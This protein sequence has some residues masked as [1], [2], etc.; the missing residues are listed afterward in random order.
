MIVTPKPFRCLSAVLLSWF[1]VASA[2]AEIAFSLTIIRETKPAYEAGY[3]QTR[4]RALPWLYTTNPPVS[5][6]RVE[7]PTDIC[8]ANFGTNTSSGGYAFHSPEPLWNALTNGQWKLWLNRDT[9]QEEFYTFTITSLDSNALAE[10]KINSPPNG[11]LNLP[12]LPPYTWTGPTNFDGLDVTVRHVTNATL[13][14]SA[15]EW[16]EGPT[17]AP[18]TNFFSV[19]YWRATTAN[20]IVSTPTNDVL[21]ALTNWTVDCI[22]LRSSAESGFITAGLPPDSLA[23][24]LDAPGLIWETGGDAPWFAQTTNASDGLD[25]AQSGVIP[26][27]G[28]T[29]LRTVLYGTNTIRFRWRTDCEVF[30]DYVEF[31]DNGNYVAD[32]TGQTVWQDFTYPLTDGQVHVLE[33]TYYKDFSEAT[34]ADAA[35]LDQVRLGADVLPTGPPLEFNL[36][37]SREQKP[38]HDPLAPNALWYSAIPGLIA[39]NVPLSYHE[40]RSPAGWFQATVGPTNTSTTIN[41]CLDFAALASEVTNGFWTLWLD[42]ET[43]QEQF[44][45]FRIDPTS[46]ASNDLNSVSITHPMNDAADVLPYTSF[47]WTGG[48]A[49]AAE[50]F[51]RAYQIRTNT[52]AFVY[53]EESLTPTSLVSWDGM[54]PL[55]PDTNF[56]TVRY[57]KAADANFSVSTPYLGWTQGNMRFE[58]SVTSSFVVARPQPTELLSPQIIG[59]EFQFQFLSQNGFT[60][61]IQSRTNLSLGNW[62]TRTNIPGDGAIKTVLLP[63]GT[64]PEEYFRVT[65]E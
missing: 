6:H 63:I 1:T 29:T 35:F 5:Y 34:G 33:W 36:T 53:A 48:L 16:L 44:Y 31:S 19:T 12:A 20:F 55:A 47:T 13:N 61:A 56:F 62:L 59:S 65:T 14:V 49:D 21:G 30:A 11:A 24:A 54:P 7:S 64:G 39:S 52:E 8:D 38:A 28:L 57:T 51:V 22:H 41:H 40:V 4:Y 37:L 15:S 2:V 25:A 3:G 17:L 26:D 60:N 43:P 45:S 58:S 42:R 32:L 23:L 50:L 46:F 10:V 27:G 18:G 9:P